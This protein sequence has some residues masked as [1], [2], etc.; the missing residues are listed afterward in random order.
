M[1]HMGTLRTFI[2]YYRPYRWLFLADLV[3]AFVISA[4]DVAYPLILNAALRQWFVH[5]IENIPHFLP[6][7]VLGLFVAYVI[8]SACRY[9]VSAQ[10]HIM[11]AYMERDMR[12]AIFQQ[13][14]RLSFSYYDRHNTGVM[15]SRVVS[16][17]FDI[18]EFAHHGPENLF[19]SLVKLAGAF[20]IMSLLFWP[21]AL[22]LALVCILMFWFSV[23]QNYRMR[24]TFM[25]NRKKIGQINASLQDSLAGIRVV[26]SFNNEDIETDKFNHANEAFLTSKKDNYYVM[27]AFQGGNAFFQG[28]LYVVVLSLGGYFVWQRQLD[29]LTLVT[30]AL[31][32]NVFISPI[33]VLVELTEMLQKGFSGFRRFLEVMKEEPDVQDRP[34]ALDLTEVKGDLQF[35]DVGFTYDGAEKVLDQVN[36]HVPA[37]KRIALV[38]PSGSGKSTLCSLIPRFYDVKQGAVLVDGHDVRDVSLSS[39][40]NAI[41]IVQQDVYLFEGSIAQNILYGKPDASYEEMVEA[42]KKANIHSFIE[43]L[44]DGYDTFVGERGARL[45]GGQKQRI[46]IARVF[47]KNPKI[48]ILD[49]ATSALDNESERIIQQSL[50]ALSKNR[51]CVTIAHRLSTIRHADEILVLNHEGIQERGTHEELMKLDGLYA[52][53]DRLQFQAIDQD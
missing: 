38:G 25:E 52:K 28:L 10:G 40:R 48:L 22:A 51:T 23:K 42:A 8:R 47:L 7:L 26:Q 12:Q 11:G 50:E 14:Q 17:L 32:V 13:Y 4:I 21:L 6:W 35:V 30:F 34:G 53:Y 27:G 39:L 33:E 18:S 37:G 2:Q 49:E 31:Y 5:D 43:Q 3:C 36:I 19:I 29:P 44:P 45:S 16:D 46:A 15:M 20:T 41:G 9:F 1:M 24:Q